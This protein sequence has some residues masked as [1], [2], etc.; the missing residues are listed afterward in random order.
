MEKITLGQLYENMEKFN[1]THGPDERIYGVIVYKAENWPDKD[2]SLECR[3]YRICNDNK[4][5]RSGMGGY[6][7]FGISLD[8]SDFCRLEHVGWEVDYCYMEDEKEV[9]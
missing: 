1:S 8:G 4:A 6:S 5:F 3:S 7:I 9:E 2:Y